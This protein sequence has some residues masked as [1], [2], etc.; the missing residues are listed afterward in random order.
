MTK[1]TKRRLPWV[2]MILGA[3]MAL[4]G[5]GMLLGTGSALQYCVAAPD[6]GEK[7][8]NYARLNRAA[9]SI[10]AALKDALA[11]T[12]A[13]G[14]A[15]EVN[16]SAGS[17]TETA[18]LTAMGEG[19]LEVYP[20][21]LVQGRRIGESE[22]QSGARV[23]M[24]DE[25]L[26]FKCF[27]ETLPEGATVKLGDVDFQV[28]GTVRHASNRWGGR[29]VGDMQR[30]DVYVP[31]LATTGAEIALDTLTLS[32]R[33]QGDGAGASQL[34]QEAAE[35]EWQGGGTFINLKKEAMRRT[36]LPRIVLLIA[37][38]YALVGLFKRMTLLAEGWAANFR[39][40]LKQSYLKPLLPR[41]LGMIALILLGYAALIGLTWLLMV[42]SAQPL[43]V[44][45]EWVPE[46]IVE[47]SSIAK[48]F[49][50]LTSDAARLL[51][52]ATREL[53]EIE[54]WGSLVRW[55]TVLTL[56]GAALLPK[57]TGRA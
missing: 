24:L 7:G 26:A 42:F 41:L 34:F 47:W 40:R 56:L 57:R 30:Y 3:A 5:L 55:G 32:A 12:A 10:G 49:W 16:V 15:S 43:Y 48:V 9:L 38:L 17:A 8:E 20:R 14:T 53:R 45:T 52:V 46:N 25:E 37:G 31:L 33:P 22:L 19:W 44:F 50:N 51:R 18:A 11:W 13:G 21:A 35:G 39:A 4:W 1:Q 27:G 6:P 2:L 28:V 36:I 29:G 54:F 23:A